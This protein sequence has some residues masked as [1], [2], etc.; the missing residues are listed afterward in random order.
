MV[1][2]EGE[3][4]RGERVWVGGCGRKSQKQT[5]TP[6]H[7]HSNTRVLGSLKRPCRA[8][9]PC[10]PLSPV[11]L[12]LSRIPSP[13]PPSHPLRTHLVS[14]TCRCTP[15]TAAA[16][17]FG[18]QQPTSKGHSAKSLTERHGEAQALPQHPALLPLSQL[19]LPV[20]LLGWHEDGSRE[21]AL[22][23]ALP[24]APSVSPL[25]ASLWQLALVAA[26]HGHALRLSE[27]PESPVQPRE[28]AWLSQADADGRFTR[29]S[30]GDARRH[31][32]T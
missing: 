24:I 10:P 13:H 11:F 18:T 27:A 23:T 5:H 31:A 1:I 14:G 32:G 8:F 6:T 28:C 15:S 9:P 26:A 22:A 25:S 3:E 20:A 12:P 7:P 2:V 19:P 30:A 21:A 4:R 17:V 16:A 29:R